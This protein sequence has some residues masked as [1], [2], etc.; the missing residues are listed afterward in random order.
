MRASFSPACRCLQ[1]APQTADCSGCTPTETLEV[2]NRTQPAV[3]LELRRLAGHAIPMTWFT[4]QQKR[5]SAE[6]DCK[7]VVSAH[8]PSPNRVVL[9]RCGCSAIA[10]KLR[11]LVIFGVHVHSSAARCNIE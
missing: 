5:S 6:R 7:E 3:R 1:E 9:R 8:R 4:E 11:E 2:P 10:P